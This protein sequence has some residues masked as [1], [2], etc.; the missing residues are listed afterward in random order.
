MTRSKRKQMK[1]FFIFVL[2]CFAAVFLIQHFFTQ[3]GIAQQTEMLFKETDWLIRSYHLTEKENWTDDTF[4]KM[5]STIDDTQRLVLLDPT[6]VILYDSDK[7]KNSEK[8]LSQTPEIEALLKDNHEKASFLDKGSA[9]GSDVLHTG[10]QIREDYELVGIISLS[11]KYYGIEGSLNRLKWGLIV[12]T[13][14]LFGTVYYLQFYLESR[15][16]RPL[17]YALPVIQEFLRHPENRQKIEI[18]SQEWSNLYDSLNQLMKS[19]NKL[20]FQQ[21]FSEE[22]LAFILENLTIGVVIFQTKDQS[23]N[24]NQVAKDLIRESDGLEEEL[25]HLLK[26]A[27]KTKHEAQKE[28]YF[29]FPFERYLNIV[30]K[31]LYF[32]EGENT[33]LVAILYDITD[34]RK[35]EQLHSDFIRN[36]S[37]ELKTPT[38]SILGFTET[39]LDGALEDSEVSGKF[40]EI[41]DKEARRLSRLI[42]NILL[43]MRTEQ[44]FDVDSI[45]WM[46][47]GK[48]IQ[49]EVEH[50]MP[51]ILSKELSVTQ[52]ISDEADVMPIPREHF[53]P[54]I[55]NLLE[56]AVNYTEVGG[57]VTLKLQISNKHL[58]LKVIDNGVGIPLEEQKRIFEKFYRVSKSR[59]RNTGG[60]G[61]GLAI[62]ANYVKLMQ[63]TIELESEVGKGTVFTVSI[64]QMF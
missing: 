18:Q 8:V 30:V 2:L 42:Q 6:G 12:G 10:K 25:N 22:K 33:E 16:R 39:L 50:Y 52:E 20:Y 28:V 26:K 46:P 40:V 35:I 53:Q 19:T 31:P 24:L 54:I 58:V 23:R 34:I 49:E 17:K 47:A 56:N 21:L 44:E 64:P 41:I 32:S 60:S 15:S 3:Q 59:Q 27:E 13:V 63:G 9:L 38:T 14:F 62:V 61:L 11:D 51:Q 48:V 45:I 4:L 29:S 1:L 37:H 36:L 7:N 43:I 5:S 55:K 57:N